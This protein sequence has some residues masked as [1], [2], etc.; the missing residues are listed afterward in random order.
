VT[1]RI[2]Q[3]AYPYVNAQRNSNRKIPPRP[4]GNTQMRPVSIYEESAKTRSLKS[5]LQ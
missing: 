2:I 3:Q 4:V 1:K 5:R